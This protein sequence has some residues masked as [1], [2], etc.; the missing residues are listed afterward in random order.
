[1]TEKNIFAYKLFL[2]LNIS[3]FSL[4]FMWK[5]Q[6]VLKKITPPSLSQQPPSKSW[7]PVKPTFLKIWLE[8]QPPPS[9]A[10]R[11]GAHY[12]VCLSFVDFLNSLKM[13]EYI[14]KYK[15]IVSYQILPKTQKLF[16][17][18]FPMSNSYLD[19]CVFTIYFLFM[20]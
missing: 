11:G 8:A 5:L 9:P 15:T 13:K 18:I 1:M 2:S 4:F 16:S 17:V 20:I 6:P 14:W 19:H 12:V 3:D 7:A 10:K